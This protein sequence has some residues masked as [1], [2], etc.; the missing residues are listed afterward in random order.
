M[1]VKRRSSPAPS[2][3][4][5]YITMGKAPSGHRWAIAVFCLIALVLILIQGL[6]W[7][8][9]ST[10]LDKI[11]A[12]EMKRELA[13]KLPSLHGQATSQFAGLRARL[14]EGTTR[15]AANTGVQLTPGIAPSN[16]PER[17]RQLLADPK[18]KSAADCW[19]SAWQYLPTAAELAE[20]AARLDLIQRRLEA[21]SFEEDDRT[22]LK[23]LVTDIERWSLLATDADECSQLIAQL[24]RLRAASSPVSPEG[25]R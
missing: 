20:H 4:L 18:A 19:D 3:T 21:R 17:L 10:K 7:V 9:S 8:S 24:L 25:A 13:A 22:F 14:D 6:L 2:Q 11:H 1:S 12:A 15:W 23:N 16:L 5:I